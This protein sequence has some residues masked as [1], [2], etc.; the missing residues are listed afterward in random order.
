MT[1]TKSPASTKAKT[2]F[3]LTNA[4]KTKP[5]TKPAI[6]HFVRHAKN[7]PMTLVVMKSDNVDGE[8]MTMMPLKKPTT[9]PDKGPAKTAAITIATSERLRLIVPSCT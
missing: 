1:G 6:V 4:L 2:L 5:A 9:A 8:T 7:V 3:L